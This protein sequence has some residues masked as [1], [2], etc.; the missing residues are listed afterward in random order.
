LTASSGRHNDESGRSDGRYRGG[1]RTPLARA[2]GRHAPR[3][4]EGEAFSKCGALRRAGGA[5]SR[6]GEWGLP[7]AAGVR[8]AHSHPASLRARREWGQQQLAAADVGDRRSRRRAIDRGAGEGVVRPTHGNGTSAAASGMMRCPR[9]T[10]G[11]LRCPIARTRGEPHAF[12][13]IDRGND[14]DA[15]PA[16]RYS[17]GRAQRGRGRFLRQG[18][19]TVRG[20][21]SRAC[22]AGPRQHRLLSIRACRA[23]ERRQ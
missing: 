21:R 1:F 19:R 9:R 10:I 16:S 17:A 8:R 14:T 11:R 13:T 2:A 6:R 12:A 3:Q 7:D 23:G 18:K 4:R 20:T 5:P 15:K 22:G